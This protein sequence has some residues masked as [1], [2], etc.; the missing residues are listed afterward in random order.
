MNRIY[1]VIWSKVKHQYV[2]V[3]ELAHSNGK[4]SR[5][6]RRS[7]RSRIA[8]LVVCG[9]IAAFGVFGAL[10]MEQA[11]AADSDYVAFV[12]GRDDNGNGINA[13]NYLNGTEKNFGGEIYICTTV[14]DPSGENHNYWVREGYSIELENVERP[15]AIGTENIDYVVRAFKTDGGSI[16]DSLVHS[17]QSNIQDSVSTLNG[18][19]LHNYDAGVYV[20]GSNGYTQVK[21]EHYTNKYTDDN[22]DPVIFDGEKWRQAERSD[23][24]ELKLNEETG[25][26]EYKGKV[27]NPENIYVLDYVTSVKDSDGNTTELEREKKTGCFVINGEVYTGQVQ[28]KN[29]EILMTG[30]DK[31][32]NYVTYWVSEYTDP[33]ATMKDMPISQYNETISGLA[34]DIHAVHQDN[35]KEIQIEQDKNGN[36]GT[37]GLQTNGEFEYIGKDPKTGEPIYKPTGGKTIP[38]GI[39]ITSIHGDDGK[40]VQVQFSNTDPDTKKTNSFTVDAGSKVQGMNNGDVISGNNTTSTTIDGLEING[41]KY[42]FDGKTYSDGSGIKFEGTDNSTISV[43]L[44]ENSGLH[45]VTKDGKQKLANNLKIESVNGDN[46]GGWQITETTDEEEGNV[47]TNTTLDAKNSND[48]N[49]E[50]EQYKGTTGTGD[51]G[52]V[53]GRDYVVKDTAGNTINLDDVASAKTLQNINVKKIGDL[54]YSEVI[55]EDVPNPDLTIHDNDTLTVAVGKLDN[56]VTNNTN[57]ITNLTETVNNGWTATVGESEINVKP[58]EDGT[59]GELNFEA[60]DNIA[61]TA[62]KDENKITI[63]ADGVVSYD[64]VAGEYVASVTL[65]GDGYKYVPGSDESQTKPSG[66]V[67]LTNVA[68]ASGDD[69][70]EA[71]NVDYLEDYVDQNGGGSWNLTTG[72]DTGNKA[73]VGKDNTVDLSGDDNITVTKTN[74]EGGGAQV[75]FGLADTVTI[76]A[77]KTDD[78]T[79]PV[80]IDGTSGYI[81]GLNNTY[82]ENN[83]EW[84][85]E[86]VI[87]N[88]AATEGQLKTVSQAVNA[89]W[90][91]YINDSEGKETKVKDV[92]P[93]DNYFT[94]KEGSH[95][96]IT[97]NVIEDVDGD[98]I[99]NGIVI[100]TDLTNLQADETNAVLYDGTDKSSV[101]LGGGKSVYNY[102]TNNPTAS[103][104]TRLTNVAYADVTKTESGSD[105]VNVDLLKDYVS[106]NG[107][108]TYTASDGININNDN[109]VSVNADT[110][111]G[112]GFAETADTDGT[113]KLEV[114]LDDTNDN[115]QFNDN[116]EISL[117]QD[118]TLNSVTTGNVVMDATGVGIKTGTGD[119]AKTNY[120]ITDNGLDANSQKITNVAAGEISESSTDAVNGSQLND[121]KAL[122]GKHT[123]MTVNGGTAA[124]AIPEG[125]TE[126][127]YNTD[128]NLQLKQMNNDGRIQ[129]DVK[130]ND[131]ITLGEGDNQIQLNGD[132]AP[133]DNETPILNVGNKFKVYQNGNIEATAKAASDDQLDQTFSLEVGGATFRAVATN[134]DYI[135]STNI[136]GGRIIARNEDK[137]EVIIN[138]ED[139]KATITG[140]TNTT[141]RN[142]ADWQAENIRADRAATEGQ[143]Q[144]VADGS[145]KYWQNDDGSYDKSFIQLEGGEEG[146]TITHLKDG[147]VNEYSS[148]AVNGSQLWETQQQI[149]NTQTEAEKHTTVTSIDK[150]VN[151]V[152]VNEDDPTKEKAYQVSLN[153]DLD[154]TSV[155][156][157]NSVMNTNG[158]KTTGE[159]GTSTT[160][161]PGNITLQGVGEWNKTT[162]G[163]S[164]ITVGKIQINGNGTQ[165]INGLSNTE[166]NGSTNTPN[167]AATEGQLESVSND[168]AS[169]NDGAVKYWQNEDGSYDKSFVQLEGGEEG[170]TI[171]HLKDGAVNEYSS[172]AVNGSQLWETQQQIKDVQTEAEKHTTMT[173]NGGTAAPAVPEGQ[174]EGE[175]NTDGNLQLKQ[176][177]TD[178]QIQY[179]VKLNDNIT[180]GEGQN[181]ISFSGDN[182]TV[183]LGEGQKTIELDGQHNTITLNKELVIDGDK[184]LIHGLS[185]NNWYDTEEDLDKKYD[186]ST[187]AATEGQLYDVYS[188][189]VKYNVDEEGNIDYNNVKLAGNTYST[190]HDEN[191]NVVGG[192]NGTRITNVAYADGTDGSE[193]VNYDLLTNKINETQQIAKQQHTTMTVNGGTEAPAD[194]TYTDGNLQLQ[195]T[196][197]INGQTQYDVKLNDTLVLG[198][199]DDT[200]NN[201]VVI[202]GNNGSIL[203]NAQGNGMENSIEIDAA[204]GTITG[205]TGAISNENWSTF[206]DEN[207]SIDSTRAAT[208]SDL[209]LVAQH[210]V[211]YDSDE[212]GVDYN[213]ITLA[214]NPY[215]SNTRE[216]GTTI[217]NLAQGE[218]DSDAVNVAQLKGYVSEN[219]T[220]TA[221]DGV[222]I[223]RNEETKENVVSVNAGDGLGFAENADENGTKKLEVKVGDN[224]EIENGAVALSDKLNLGDGQIIIDATENN[225][226][227]TIGNVNEEGTT[228]IT[229]SKDGSANFG[230]IQI[231]NET[232]ENTITGL[233]NTEWS[234]SGTYKSGRAATEEQLSDVA[235][236]AEGQIN[237]SGWTVSTNNG[238]KTTDIK[239][240]DTVDFS[241]TDG[242]IKVSQK[243]TEDGTQLL[244][245]LNDQINIGQ[246]IKLDGTTGD[247]TFGNIIIGGSSG[248]ISGLTNVTWNSTHD[249][250]GSTQAATEAQLQQAVNDAKQEVTD[251]DRHLA[252]NSGTNPDM[253]DATYAPDENGNV[254]IKEV[255]GTGKPT[256][257]EVVISDVASASDLGNVADLND[258]LLNK[259]GTDTSVVDAV[260]NLDDKVG[261]GDFTGTTH[262]DEETDNITDAIKDLDSAITDAATEAG[263]HSTVSDGKNIDVVETKNPNGSTDYKVSLNDDITLGDADGNNV[264]LSGTNG[265]ISAT[266]NVNAGS[267]TSGSIT[268]NSGNSGTIGGLSNKTWDFSH[269]YSQSGQAATEAQLHAVSE[270]S[271]QYDRN[272][273]GSVNKGSITLGGGEEGTIIH[274]VAPGQEATDAANVGQLAEVANNSYTAINNV[275]N[276]VNRLSNRIDKVGAGAAALAAL[277]PL[278]F[279]P[280]DKL[281]FAAGY[282]NYAGENAVAVGAFYQPNEDT[283]FSVGG[284]FGND[285]NM[286]NAGVSFKL[287]QKS[288]VSRSRVSMAKELVALRDEVA[289]LKALMAH[290]GIL[291]ANGQLD[292]SDMFPDIPENH[293]AY[294]YVHELAKLGIVDGYPD[295]NF[296]GDRMMTRYEMAAIVYRAMQKGVN[297]DK[298]MLT[299]FEPELKLIRVDV[300]ARDDNG[301]P[302]IERVR[303]ND[304]ATQQA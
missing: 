289:Q 203:V 7:L 154:V 223:T 102:N 115:L 173:V 297:V 134:G 118:L 258:D 20:G 46:K 29:N 166:W 156:T 224:L 12:T 139:G 251:A 4:Q 232:G 106:Q 36:G 300:V 145:V 27:V 268:I 23:F 250:S 242:N 269:D 179:D 290:S 142:D 146:T 243:V 80:T 88:R 277:H 200:P 151:I 278:D 144:T 119:E 217:T 84:I 234:A 8:A 89:G 171:T 71:V 76:G 231:N 299:E 168:V 32:K 3:S 34:S 264:Q 125:Q 178:G 230:A 83:N 229:L 138:G 183:I 247:A 265:T 72:K 194:E 140:L 109:E 182:G 186:R 44:A 228:G 39:K 239:N 59:A 110:T 238:D 129:Y 270:G 122:A 275:G 100:S 153:P 92:R 64:K 54:Q 60:G 174:T 190:V 256:G 66:G 263:K 215:N 188:S 11:F 65:G 155:T 208:E 253:A 86:N 210:S 124:P 62:D 91:A 120:Y 87:S 193:A 26:Y 160:I 113:K 271:V 199:S 81:T 121:V 245:N 96:N 227:I 167:R 33:S 255:D 201:N 42:S 51:E 212:N 301:N 248:T 40:D 79:H 198:I 287:G 254:T 73:V 53:Y 159:G 149:K 108:E 163:S 219:A 259:D 261:S 175:Y 285:E 37:I 19:N 274:N 147:A 2:V 298:R 220:Y 117:N 104:G 15:G 202:D 61:L 101:T 97:E 218:N 1:K 75:T 225:G 98:K 283:M 205:L 90:V 177:V 17:Y 296:E 22:N 303:V 249:Y 78:S 28:G 246:K 49:N 294:E 18:S 116:G 213:K 48:T 288:N 77:E 41:Q 216:G 112:L 272:E 57:S 135:S 141:W 111:K 191:G 181:A 133:D 176:T 74:T 260:N 222:N 30:I 293:W 35:I 99:T 68:Y 58:N 276:Q 67:K 233:T 267:F 25:Y 266:G 257:N 262:I 236:W 24:Q 148:D 206:M 105:A 240:G 47:F 52:V 189:A 136:N 103:G 161:T 126:G 6:A 63:A 14:E 241:N 43:D 10:P 282:G 150:N 94:F 291:P 95:I 107:G 280:D 244:F 192:N 292:T 70:S 164:E 69:K 207:S 158:F 9:A 197:G 295:G 85:D 82:W 302:T 252:T 304:E 279:D 38:G 235:D 130:L 226:Y 196:T 5:T 131:N 93:G 21:M 50:A 273:D 31:N 13:N 209:R 114:K 187:V 195:K 286:V 214:G 165:V 281:S 137:Q 56:R 157:G 184:E 170:T 211:Q 204:T 152:N 128:G 185:N 55:D 169:L 127:E 132:I 143:L 180:L 284:T 45:F 123:I 237:N 162:I 172:D 221:G 16:D